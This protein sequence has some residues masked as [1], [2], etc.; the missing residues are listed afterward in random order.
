MD[1]LKKQSHLALGYFVLIA[2]LGV[3]L[4]VF[5][6]ADIPLD[7]RNVV[8]T[9]SHIALLGWVYSGLMILIYH[10]FLKHQPIEQSY[11]RLFW[12]T[13]I[14]VVGML[15]TFPF[16]GYAL[17]SI[18]FSSLFIIASY[19]FA[20]MVF[21]H[22]PDKLK[23]TNAY[24]CIRIALWYMILSSLGPWALGAI[25]STLG[26]G[27]DLYRNAIYF[28]LHFQY[29][30]WFI[31]ALL[32]VLIYFLDQYNIQLSKQ[33][34]NRF[35]RLMNIGVILTFGISILWM[36]SP[37]WIYFLSGLGG[38]CQ[39]VGL[40]ILLTAIKPSIPKLKQHIPK[41]N[42]ILIASVG[43]IYGIKLLM[44]FAGTFPYLANQ[45]ANNPDFIIGYI[46]WIFLGVVSPA[47]LLFLNQFKFIKLS[48][49]C[50]N[51]YWVGF[52]LTEGLIFYKGITTWL[53]NSTM[54]SYY[55]WLTLASIILLGSLTWIFVKQPTS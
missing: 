9:H 8:H 41:L 1:I 30:G 14:T 12:I 27:S 35:Y 20:K 16:T 54:D 10:I 50:L 38:L 49:S 17:F 24:K 45:I 48:K 28:Y 34:F 47:I 29:N 25:M 51:L 6:L 42:M 31:M 39:L 13:Q 53:T 2:L 33:V 23:Q 7:Y 5:H 43:L 26:S 3:L 37:Q 40:G 19:G 36:N 4:R 15:V 55:L 18:L 21:K 11:H 32:G 46:H 44:Q 52:L 22:T